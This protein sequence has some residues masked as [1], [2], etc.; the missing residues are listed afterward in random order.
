MSPRRWKPALIY[1]FEHSHMHKLK[2]RRKN[3]S[4]STM[5]HII[6]KDS[7]SVCF[8]GFLCFLIL[9]G[10]VPSNYSILN[11][12]DNLNRWAPNSCGILLCCFCRWKPSTP[13]T[14]TLSLW[15]KY[16]GCWPASALP[17]G[18]CPSMWVTFIWG[19]E[20]MRSQTAPWCDLYRIKSFIAT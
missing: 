5:L 20:T 1:G 4:K 18:C 12:N 13:V 17:Y 19:S 11:P 15:L 16:Y 2:Q 10:P 6:F 8:Y 9:S 14:G 3:I 7:Y